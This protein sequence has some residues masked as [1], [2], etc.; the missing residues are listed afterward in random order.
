VKTYR[1]A[2]AG[3]LLI[4]KAAIAGP[5]SVKILSL[6]V[7]TGSSYTIVPVEVLESCGCSP[8]E[9]KKHLRIV[10]G[11]GFV[12]APVVQLNWFSTL[13]IKID[14]FSV[15]AHTLPFSGPIDGL[16]GMDLLRRIKARIDLENSLI[17]I[18]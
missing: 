17:E 10:T 5:D 2:N 1:L 8:A 15:V 18:P 12:V 16:L 9:A 4:T 6:L 3:T 11:S 14:N 7:D 13:G